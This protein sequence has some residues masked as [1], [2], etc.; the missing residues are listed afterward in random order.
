MTTQY[1]SQ[2]FHTGV[3]ILLNDFIPELNELQ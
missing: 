2:I 1:A 3:E